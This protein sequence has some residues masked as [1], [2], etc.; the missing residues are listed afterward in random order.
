MFDEFNDATQLKTSLAKYSIK[1]HDLESASN[2][3]FKAVRQTSHTTVCEKV[4]GQT[5]RSVVL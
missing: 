5:K 4:C 1:F 3:V 2:S